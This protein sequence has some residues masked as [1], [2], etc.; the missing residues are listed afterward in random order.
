[1]SSV[2]LHAGP[3]LLDTAWRI[4]LPVAAMSTLGILADSYFDSKPW[5]ALLGLAVGCAFAG[6]LVKQQAIDAPDDE[7]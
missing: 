5:L 6:I 2:N 3:M 1:M 7:K 4:G